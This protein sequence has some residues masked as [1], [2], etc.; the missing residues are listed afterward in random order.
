MKLLD[1]VGHCPHLSA[2][3]E[4]AAAIQAFSSGDIWRLRA[5]CRI[6]DAFILLA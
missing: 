2:P 1:A 3:E 5:H 4:V 6:E